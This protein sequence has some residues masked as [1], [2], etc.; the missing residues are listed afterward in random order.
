MVLALL[1]AGLALATPAAHARH[2]GPQ[3]GHHPAKPL[4]VMTRNLYLGADINRPVQAALAAQAGGGTQTDV[5]LA[6][7]HA[8]YATR[9]IVDQTNFPVRAGLLADE[10]KRTHPDLVGLQE[11]AWW[12][13][14]PLQLTQVG[15]PNAD[16]TDYDFLATLLDALAQRGQHYVPVVVGNRA[17]VEGP[18]FTGSPFDGTMGADARDVRL[19]MRDVI[20]KRKSSDLRV[21]GH[22]DH[23]YATNLSVP[24][25]GSTISFDRGY[26]WVDVRDGS[27]RLRF[28]NTHLEAFSAD[29]AAAQATELLEGAPA[30]DRTTV[31]VCDCN[32]DPLNHSVDTSI[33]DTLPHSAAYDLITGQGGFTDEWLTWAPAADGWTSG[34]SE[35]VDDP[36]AA[37]F[38]HRID[39]V[40]ARTARGSGLAVDKGKVTGTKPGDRDPGTGLWPSDHG[41]VVLRLRGY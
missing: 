11:V 41:G 25:A 26:E 3:G 39:M 27:K 17:D 19:T 24:V 40:F 32:S 30:T 15:V 23:V 12:R 13:H 1:M 9:A 18:S 4:T 28:V 22:G 7:A 36:T 35:T 21:T 2:D 34:L 37:G 29:I 10:I 16:I 20:L 33:G 6:L 38:D 5:L 31:L 8:T 14:G